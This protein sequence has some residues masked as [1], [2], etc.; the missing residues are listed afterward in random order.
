M[1]SVIKFEEFSHRCA[2]FFPRFSAVLFEAKSGNIEETID[3]HQRRLDNTGRQKHFLRS[4]LGDR[5][6][7]GKKRNEDTGESRSNPGCWRQS[8]GR[9]SL[10]LVFIFAGFYRCQ[11]SSSS[12]LILERET[13]GAHSIILISRFTSNVFKKKKKKKK[14]KEGKIEK[15][16]PKLKSF[17]TS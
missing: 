15:F 1:S 8:Q 17:L 12:L 16:N 7:K 5:N 11:R 9:N 6:Q 13:L 3:E 4:Y 14:R 10:R 2:S